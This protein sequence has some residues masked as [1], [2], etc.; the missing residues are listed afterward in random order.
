MFFVN[1]I[2]KY[3]CFGLIPSLVL[4]FPISQGTSVYQEALDISCI[5][6]HQSHFVDP[7][8]TATELGLHIYNNMSVYING[9]N[10]ELDRLEISTTAGLYYEYDLDGN[11]LGEHSGSIRLCF[12]MSNVH[13]FVSTL[14]IN[15]KKL[16]ESNVN[17]YWFIVSI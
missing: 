2:L 10:I 6:F 12:E 13:S 5:S 7:S 14:R 3:F 16:D 9:Q 1:S 8:I 17:Y 4:I 11:L 15:V